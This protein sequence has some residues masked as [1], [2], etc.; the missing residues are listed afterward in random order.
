MK[1][2]SIKIGTCCSTII[3]FFSLIENLEYRLIQCNSI[4]T[5]PQHSSF[6]D[7]LQEGES[8][9]TQTTCVSWNLISEIKKNLYL[10]DEIHKTFKILSYNN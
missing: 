9:R 10:E 7:A 8:R 2:R 3:I 5:L 4:G 1:V 6:T